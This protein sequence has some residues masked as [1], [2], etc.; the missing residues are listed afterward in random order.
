[1]DILKDLLFILSGFNLFETVSFIIF[2]LLGFLAILEN[3]A[4]L[5]LFNEQGNIGGEV[6][7]M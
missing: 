5:L 6:P 7:Q 2:Y 4:Y 3:C 1:M